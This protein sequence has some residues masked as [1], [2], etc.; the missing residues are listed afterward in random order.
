MLGIKF[1]PILFCKAIFQRITKQ[2]RYPHCH[3]KYCSGTAT[4]KQ[5]KAGYFLVYL[6][7]RTG[8]IKCCLK[9]SVWSIPSRSEYRSIPMQ[10]AFLGKLIYGEKRSNKRAANAAYLQTTAANQAIKT[11][12]CK[13]SYC[14]LSIA[15]SRCA[16]QSSGR[17]LD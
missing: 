6:W 4:M 13:H 1:S 17:N 10:E 16:N 14:L 15:F 12:N 5:G 3:A 8:R 11:I 2:F 9:Q 7:E